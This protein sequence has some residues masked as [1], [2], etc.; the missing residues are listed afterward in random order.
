MGAISRIDWFQQLYQRNL[1]TWAFRP[2]VIAIAD[3]LFEKPETV[4]AD[5]NLSLRDSLRKALDALEHEHAAEML[6]SRRKG[7][8]LDNDEQANAPLL[9]RSQ[10]FGFT[11]RILL[12][13]NL[14]LNPNAIFKSSPVRVRAYTGR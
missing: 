2:T 7:C 5:T 8:I 9:K 13:A 3:T 14:I 10:V 6:S 12:R 1:F 11:R 4:M